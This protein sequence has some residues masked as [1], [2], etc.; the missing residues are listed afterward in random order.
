[1]KKLKKLRNKYNSY[2]IGFKNNIII[3]LAFLFITACGSLDN[4]DIEQQK[5]DINTLKNNANDRNFSKLTS[6]N[7]L[8]P[9]LLGGKSS[10]NI[11]I[12]FEV[13]LDEF[14]IMP[15]IMAD[16][17]NGII[18]TDWYSTSNSNERAKFNI[19]IKDDNMTSDSIILKMFKEKL[20]ENGWVTIKTNN[21][22]VEKLKNIILDKSIDLKAV[23]ELS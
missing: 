11:F 13:A 8:M 12:T 20:T 9:E 6:L 15:L 23:A 14:S 16:K 21:I 4:L 7:D 10:L 18:I 1:M 2:S 3:L 5:T 22:T 17:D 19:L